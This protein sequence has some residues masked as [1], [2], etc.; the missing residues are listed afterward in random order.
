ME[1][2]DQLQTFM[3]HGMCLL[4]KPELMILHIGSDALIAL[5]Y[6]AIPFGI[7]QFVSGRTD[8]DAKHRYLALL[9]AGFIGLCGVTHVASILVLWYPY[10]VTEGWLKAVTA[11]ASMATA[12]FALTLVPALLRLPSAQSLQNEIDDHR[13]TLSKLDAARASLALR[14][15]ATEHELRVAERNYAQSDNLLH[16]VI[17]A[18]PGAIYAKDDRGRMLLAN[19]SA[20]QAI[21]EPWTFVEGKSVDD[22]LADKDQAKA[23]MAND[24]LVIETGLKQEMEEIISTPSGEPRIFL[25]TKTPLRN[26]EGLPSGIVGISIDITERKASEL[27]ARRRIEDALSEKTQALE[28]RDILIRE[29]YHRVKNNLQI[30][31]S[32]LVLQ[33]RIISDDIAKKALKSLRNR[34]Y[35]LGL[36]HHQLMSAADFATFDISAFLHEL[37]E[38]LVGGAASDSIELSVHAEP[39]TVGLDFAIPFGLVVTELVTNAM[40]H[41]FPLGGGTIAVI[42]T[43][44]GSD[45]IMLV[46]KDNGGGFPNAEPAASSR[47][48]GLGKKIVDGMVRQL[49]GIVTSRFENGT[50]VDVLVQEPQL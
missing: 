34:I 31:D 1:W 3:P 17:E 29:V 12:V 40:K 48:A 45:R 11:A 49:N 15:D 33:D 13:V 36:V 8:L 39:I 9:F 42:V 16:T 46:V 21:G 44:V 30:V 19:R 47:P 24:T 38:N 28:Q 4:W 25:S 35:A 7:A 5:A 6:F 10:Y 37:A 27:A 26:D 41:A 43:R 23:I 50:I 32:F 2:F 22:F 20:L 14:V 18:V